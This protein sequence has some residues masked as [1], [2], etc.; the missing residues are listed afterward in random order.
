MVDNLVNISECGL[1]SVKL[2]AFINAKSNTKKFQFGKEKCHKLHI[3]CKDQNCPDLYLDTWKIEESEEYDTGSKVIKDVIDQDYKIESSEEERYLGDL[4]TSDGKNTK[5]ILARKS[6]G[7]GIVDKICNHLNNVFFGPYHFQTALMFRESM[8][9][10]SILVN[11]E[12]WY[13]L[14]DTDIKNI[15]SVDNILHRRLLETATSTPISIMHLELGTL[16]LR[17]VIKGRRLVFLQYI[18]KQDK[19]E[20]IFK[21]FEAQFSDPNK[22]D[23]VVQAKQDLKDVNLDITFDQISIMSDYTYQAKVKR[24]ITLS[25]YNWLISEKDKQRSDSA[26]KGISLIYTE[27]K[28]QDYFL[29]NNTLNNKQR[30]LLFSLRSRMV[31]VRTNFSHSYSELTCPVCLDKNQRDTQ[32]HLLHCKKLLAGENLLV[33]NEISYDDLFSTDVNKQAAVVI[34]LEKLLSKRRD[35]EKKSSHVSDPSDPNSTSL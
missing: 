5:N 8:L 9:L 31:P 10:N 35:L 33:G 6:K 24:A 4:I 30:N 20:L 12:S 23:W 22:G 26:P 11:S 21:I 27:L 13:N 28:L 15:E 32:V 3:G 18:L 29:P 1:E 7:I 17:Y 25:A 2:N 34:L 19:D 14:S 16:P